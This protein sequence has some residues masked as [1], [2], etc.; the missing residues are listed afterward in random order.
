MPWFK[1]TAEIEM[2]IESRDEESARF[3]A[4]TI[5]YKRVLGQSF[6]N[7]K[8]DRGEVK[9]ARKIE[10]FS[11]PDPDDEFEET[12]QQFR[13]GPNDCPDC[14]AT[15]ELRGHMGC[16]SPSDDPNI[17]GLEDPMEFER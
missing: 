4:E 5:L 1:A 3:H 14:G 13:S 7:R 9:A 12:D 15:N 10:V 8:N 11:D 6:G 17:E 16:L 2:E